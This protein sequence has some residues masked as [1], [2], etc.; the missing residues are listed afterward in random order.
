MKPDK[1]GFL[2]PQI[3]QAQCVN[4]GICYDRCPAASGTERREPRFVY[5]AQQ[6]EQDSLKKS[7]SG[8]IAALLAARILEKGGAVYGCAFDEEVRAVHIRVDKPEH[9]HRL[10]GSKY[11]QSDIREVLPA[12]KEDCVSGRLTAFFG[13]PCQVAV[14][15][16]YVG[17][18]ASNLL[19]VDLICHGTPSPALFADY[20]QWK[21]LRMGGGKIQSFLFRDKSVWNW[22]T[23]YRATTSTATASAVI[24]ASEDPYYDAFLNAQTFRECCYSCHYA[25]K[26][27][28]GDITLGDFWG[29]ENQHP[30]SGLDI[31][32]GVSVVL[33][34]TDA[35]VEAFEEITQRLL[36]CK[37]D[38]RKA[39]AENGNLL[40]PSQRPPIRDVYYEM[41]DRH[42]YAW[43]FRYLRRQKRYYINK[44]KKMLPRKLKRRLKRLV[45]R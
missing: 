14:V 44:L 9:L 1:E 12:I 24:T 10:A 8:G 36:L 33:L 7:S 32:A 22:G 4:C 20:L 41:V 35:G 15:R 34:N 26:N 38:F 16:N 5:A 18:N 40:H 23:A 3:D 29:I 13:T 28:T 45:R 30:E 31:R 6:W 17:R 2:F 19:L 37:S 21:A 42:G 43:A 25:Q 11:V 39:A 27:R